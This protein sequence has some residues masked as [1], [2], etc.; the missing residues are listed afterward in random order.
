[1]A[2]VL[3]VLTFLLEKEEGLLFLF[4]HRLCSVWL[5][6]AYEDFLVP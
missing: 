5:I 4:L 1:M 2:P 3:D 6:L